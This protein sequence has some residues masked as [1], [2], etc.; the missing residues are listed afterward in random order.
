MVFLVAGSAGAQTPVT[1]VQIAASQHV[2]VLTSHGEVWGWGQNGSGQLGE[3]A[4]A[5]VRSTT[6]VAHPIPIPL[7]GRIVSVCVAG[8]TSYAVL[9]DGSVLAWG[10]GRNGQLGNGEA[11]L[12]ART[13]IGR[14][15]SER[16]VRVTGLTGLVQLACSGHRAG[17]DEGRHRAGVGEP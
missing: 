5:R 4:G 3:A 14:P 11:G 13:K 16:P 12:E 15:G 9:E 1:I 7:P 10:D 17:P 2:L 8:E 6:W